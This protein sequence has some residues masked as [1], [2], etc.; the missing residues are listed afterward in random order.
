MATVT[1]FVMRLYYLSL[2][3]KSFHS[4]ERENG[5]LYQRLLA[6]SHQFLDRQA[7]VFGYLP[8]Q[9]RGKIPAGM[10]GNCCAAAIQTSILL[11]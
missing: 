7:Y 6:D 4:A 11:V 3:F 5:A 10:K 9:E 8:E 2:F 1:I